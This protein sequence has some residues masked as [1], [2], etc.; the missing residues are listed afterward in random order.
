VVKVLEVTKSTYFPS[1]NRLCIE[2]SAA[3]VEAN[4][5]VNYLNPLVRSFE[6]LNM[7]DE[8]PQMSEL[9]KPMMHL[10]M[11]TWKHSRYYNSAARLVVL[12]RE[13][14]NDLITQGCNYVVGHEIMQV[15]YL[16]SERSPP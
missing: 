6:R 16:F 11:L 10:L 13:I 1:F 8:F 4:N 3:R 12:M 14:C 7:S 9:F 2:V 15:N 5:N